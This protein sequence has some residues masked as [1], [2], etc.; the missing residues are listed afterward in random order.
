MKKLKML[1]GLALLLLAPCLVHAEGITDT[2]TGM[3]P[4]LDNVY[5]QMLPLCAKL[6]DVAQGIAGFAALWYI[7]SR[8]WK[9]IAHAEPIEFYPLIRPFALGI[10]IGLFQTLVIPVMNGV[11]QPVVEVT[12]GMV[13]DSNSAITQLL[14]QKQDAVKNSTMYQIYIGDDGN[15]SQEKWYKYTHPDDPDGNNEGIIDGLGNDVKFFLDKQSYNFRNSIKQWLSE[16]L[17]VVYAASSLCINTLRVF[18]LIVLAILGP[19]VF[20][21]SVFDGFQHS[22][23]QWFARYINIFLWLPIANIFGSIIG[24]IQQEMLKMDIAQIQSAGDT[25]FNQTDTAY[26]IFLLIGIVGYFSVPTVANFVVHAHGHNGMLQR[27]S[28]IAS[29][30]VSTSAAMAGSAGSATGS[31]MASGAVNILKTPGYIKDGYQGGGKDSFQ[32]DKLSGK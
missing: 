14:K 2:L 23:T 7:G 5:K 30:T 6:I 26:L 9:Q 32:K 31:R 11:L 15:G 16:V 20:G 28:S 4:V 10:A 13:K 17:E 24:Q 18:F 21:L 29:T 19:L 8:V 12:N 1:T 25:F 3:Q 22:L 27:V